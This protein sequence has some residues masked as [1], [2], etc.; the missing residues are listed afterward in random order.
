MKKLERT[1]FAYEVC[2][3]ACGL[4]EKDAFDIEIERISFWKDRVDLSNILDGG[5]GG[6]VFKG[7][8]H[9]MFGRRRPDLAEKN[10]SRIWTEEAKAKIAEKLSGFSHS[11]ETR[12]KMSQSKIGKIRGKYT[13]ISDGIALS[14]KARAGTEAAKSAAKKASDARWSKLRSLEKAK[15]DNH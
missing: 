12:E 10:K 6:P 3:V 1:G 7:K 15:S 11:A 13:V 5:N 4:S 8:E 9:P 14:N 2:I